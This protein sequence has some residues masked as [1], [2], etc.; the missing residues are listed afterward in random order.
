L[1]S[2]LGSGAMGAGGG[3]ELAPDTG[4]VD[5]AVFLLRYSAFL[6]PL[7][8]GRTDEIPGDNAAYRREALKRHQVSARTGFWE[9][10]FHRKLRAEGGH[11]VGVPGATVAFGPSLSVGS[12]FLQRFR[13]GKQFGDYRVR[14]SRDGGPSGSGRP[15]RCL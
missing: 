3:L 5:W 1:L 10:E 7:R 11:L 2:G 12:F 8:A 9:V 15:P 6:A 4:V 13:H 14:E